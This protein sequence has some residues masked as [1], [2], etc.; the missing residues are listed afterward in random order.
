MKN[1]CPW[2]EGD[3][4]YE[5][6]HDEEWGVPQRDGRALFA[7]LVLDGFQAGL[8]WL[9]ILRKRPAFY[10]AFHGF[11]PPRIARYSERDFERLMADAGIVRN[12]AKIRATLANARAWLDIES[13]PGGFSGFVWSFVGGKPLVHRFSEN[14]QIPAETEEARALSQALKQRGFSFVGPTIVYAFMQACGLVNDHL[15]TCPRWK[16]VQKAR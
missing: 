16:G 12:R 10:A 2:A 14:G 9:T 15:L 4:L 5:A 6:Y 13:E 1:R 3:P 11:D 7:N 8:S